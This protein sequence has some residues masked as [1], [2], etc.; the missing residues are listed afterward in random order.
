MKLSD[1]QLTKLAQAFLSYYA[2]PYASTA[3]ASQAMLD[4]Y[5]SEMRPKDAAPV[6]WRRLDGDHDGMVQISTNGHWIA[7]GHAPHA[8]HYFTREDLLSIPFPADPTPE[9]KAEAEFDAYWINRPCLGYSANDS[10]AK[11]LAKSAFMA[12]K[13]PA[14]GGGK[15]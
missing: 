15:P 12:A 8:T 11:R 9:E 4:L 3:G 6:M 13:F 14:E 7:V 5:E 10:G 1:D 2:A